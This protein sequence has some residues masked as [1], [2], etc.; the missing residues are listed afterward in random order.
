MIRRR[1]PQGAA[2]GYAVWVSVGWLIALAAWGAF[3]FMDAYA[4]G[5]GAC[6]V[7]SLRSC[8]VVSSTGPIGPDIVQGIG[9]AA[10]D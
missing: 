10:P 5:L 6:S 3:Y 7:L 1:K 2:K 9:K 4:L 8:R